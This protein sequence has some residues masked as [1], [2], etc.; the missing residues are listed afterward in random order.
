[1]NICKNCHQNI[2]SDNKPQELQNYCKHCEFI[3][4]QLKYYKNSIAD[5]LVRNTGMSRSSS[6]LITNNLS[7]M[8]YS[9][10]KLEQ[11]RLNPNSNS[12]F[13]NQI[14]EALRTIEKS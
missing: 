1:M 5:S 11:R 9:F 4:Q 14:S 3:V 6:L 13:L 2:G 8:M 7:D 10:L 12:M